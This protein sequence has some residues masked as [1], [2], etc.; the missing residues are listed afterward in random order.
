M[1]TIALTNRN[2]DLR[3]VKNCLDS[4]NSQ[5][6]Q[7]FQSIVVDYGSEEEYILELQKRLSQYPKIKFISCPVSGQL[8]SKCRAINIALKQCETPYF[9]VGDIDLIFD[10]NFI[11]TAKSLAKPNEVH[12]FQYGFLSQ[13]ESLKTK[14]FED[15]IVDFNGNDEVTGTTLF[16]TALLQKLNGYDEFY[17]GWGAEDT[18]IHIRIKNEGK[19]LL[20]YDK[21]ILIK[22]QW[23]PKTY[24]SKDSSGPFHSH[25][26]RINHAY[27]MQGQLTK[28]TKANV[29]IEWGE[30]PERASY[31]KLEQP[32]HHMQIDASLF[33]VQA[34][35]AQLANF[36]NETV[37]LTVKDLDGTAKIK[38]KMKRL[39]G[40]KYIP[41]LDMETIN[42]M[43]LEEIIKSYRNCP[44][45]YVF[46]RKKNTISLTIHVDL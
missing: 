25:L 35:L 33:Q 7:G 27:M 34:F 5:T 11:E 43:L 30:M 32:Q 22:H 42:N 19:T 4:L 21:A 23:H 31:A 13:D 8:W 46:D 26:E 37:Q 2:R 16:P 20:F 36:E 40:K 44:Y 45:N 14:Q 1:I 29:T 41:I 38:S 9:M 24:R 28:R 3:I 10:P 6:S 18:D 12:Y 39:L 17:H 15:Y